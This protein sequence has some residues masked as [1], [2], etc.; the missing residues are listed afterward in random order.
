MKS[1]KLKSKKWKKTVDK[2][3]IPIFG[4]KSIGARIMGFGVTMQDLFD[5][6]GIPRI[7]ITMEIIENSFGPE[8]GETLFIF[9]MGLL[10]G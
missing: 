4:E 3:K 9:L 6:I 1:S 5:L 2:I 10:G 8:L 7:F